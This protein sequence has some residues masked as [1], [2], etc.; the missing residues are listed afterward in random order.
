MFNKQQLFS[1]HRRELEVLEKSKNDDATKFRIELEQLKLELRQQR[2]IEMLR[3]YEALKGSMDSLNNK[4][5]FISSKVDPKP[6]RH[7]DITALALANEL[8]MYPI[9]SHTSKGV[10]PKYYKIPVGAIDKVV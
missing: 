4:M 7:Y 9:V 2:D 10:V 5:A 3:G 1:K 6:V 8:K